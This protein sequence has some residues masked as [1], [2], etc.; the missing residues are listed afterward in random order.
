MKE[1]QHLSFAEQL[2]RHR[3]DRGLTQEELAEQASLSA[4]GI[5][6]L[7]QG[8]RTAPHSYTVRLLADA[9]QLGRSERR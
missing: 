1:Q 9:L 6:A 5:R 2:K 4:R 8:E 7:E 3:R